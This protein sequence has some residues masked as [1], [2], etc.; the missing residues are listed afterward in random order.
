MSKELQNQVAIVTGGSRGYGAGMAAALVNAGAKVWITGR[1]EERLLETASKIGAK[2]FVA[3]AADGAAWDS[4]M[5]TVMAESG[6]LD[7]LVNNAGEGVSIAPTRELS[8]EVI[9]RSIA[10]NLTGALLGCRRA[11]GSRARPR[12]RRWNR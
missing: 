8:D 10:S 6:K 4:L 9:E 2:E 11:A 5:E 1:N 7:V 3:D 12:R